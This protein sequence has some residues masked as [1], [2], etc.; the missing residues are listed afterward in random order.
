M[1]TPIMKNGTLNQW[2]FLIAKTETD[3]AS[4]N[5]VKDGTVAS[6]GNKVGW[7]QWCVS[8]GAQFELVQNLIC[9]NVAPGGTSL[10]T[11]GGVGC[12]YNRSA[13]QDLRYVITQ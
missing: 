4:S 3:G 10:I 5:W 7:V 2:A 1:Y 6:W 12:T 8:S 13:P 11:T 9:D